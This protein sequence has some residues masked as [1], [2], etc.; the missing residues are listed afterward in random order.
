MSWDDA[1]I[2]AH[3]TIGAAWL[4]VAADILARGRPSAYDGMPIV[5]I[6]QATLDVARPDPDDAIDMRSQLPAKWDAAPLRL[7]KRGEHDGAVRSVYRVGPEGDTRIMLV[8][9]DATA[10]SINSLCDRLAREQ[11]TTLMLL[12]GYPEPAIPIV[13]AIRSDHR[14][15]G[16]TIGAPAGQP[17]LAQW[18]TALDCVQIDSARVFVAES[19]GMVADTASANAPMLHDGMETLADGLFRC[20]GPAA[21]TMIPPPHVKRDHDLLLQIVFRPVVRRADVVEAKAAA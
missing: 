17:E 4:A 2:H 10:L 14:L 9:L 5:E 11:V 8:E 15:A 7:I 20:A 13:K 6:A 16:L 1:A 18:G 19:Y 21:L 12:V 3:D